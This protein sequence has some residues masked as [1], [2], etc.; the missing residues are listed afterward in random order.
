MIFFGENKA[1]TL[2]SKNSTQNFQP[3]LLKT[4][5]GYFLMDQSSR[6]EPINEKFK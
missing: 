5:R 3:G 6:A 2:L 1:K 4:E